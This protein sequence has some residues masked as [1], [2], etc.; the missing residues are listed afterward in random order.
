MRPVLFTFPDSESFP[1][2]MLLS[3]SIWVWAHPAL[4][5]L[6]FLSHA[7][8]EC[9]PGCV[10]VARDESLVHCQQKHPLALLGSAMEEVICCCR[11]SWGR[12]GGRS[13]ESHRAQP[14]LRGEQTEISS[15]S[16]GFILG[17]HSSLSPV[18]SP[19]IPPPSAP[20]PTRWT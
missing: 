5:F 3:L 20:R 1:P 17:R 7:G 12:V 19:R 11:L 10:T 13:P 4:R 15:L 14:H 16:A 18:G 6:C 8:F 9:C 2:F